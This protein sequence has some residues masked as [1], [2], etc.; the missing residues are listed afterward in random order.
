MNTS[1]RSMNKPSRPGG[2]SSRDLMLAAILV[3]LTGGLLA[4]GARGQG[5]FDPQGHVFLR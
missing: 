2:L 4:I 3:L 5:G 1:T